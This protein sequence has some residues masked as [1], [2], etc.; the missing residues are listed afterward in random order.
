MID[1]NHLTGHV[2]AHFI[3]AEGEENKQTAISIPL[4]LSV[5]RKFADYIGKGL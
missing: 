5:R 1:V 3:K 2:L 4:P